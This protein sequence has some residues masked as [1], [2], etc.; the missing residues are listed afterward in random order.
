MFLLGWLGTA[1]LIVPWFNGRA[2]AYFSAMRTSRGDSPWPSWSETLGGGDHFDDLIHRQKDPHLETLRRRVW[3]AAVVW[4]A[5]LFFGMWIWTTVLR[6][7][8]FGP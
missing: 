3:I 5:Y 7:M 4:F 2:K 1:V 6:L 8:G